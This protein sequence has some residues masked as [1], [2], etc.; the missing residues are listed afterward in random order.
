MAA[1]LAAS[2][3][4]TRAEDPGPV[5]LDG[6]PSSEQAVAATKPG[7]VARAR[8]LRAKLNSLGLYPTIRA[9]AEGTGIGPGLT[10]WKPRAFGGPV[11]FLATVGWSPRVLLA[12]ARLGRVP[13]RPDHIPDRRFTLEALTTDPLGDP[14]HQAFL[15]L[16]ARTIK[17]K[18]DRL[19]FS[20]APNGPAEPVPLP[21]PARTPDEAPDPVEIV[22]DVRESDADLVAGYHFFQGLSASARVGYVRART[23]FD[24]DQ[25]LGAAE[26]PPVPG[27]NDTTDFARVALDLVVDRR[28]VRSRAR[29]GGLLHARWL[30]MDQRGGAFYG[31]E[32]LELDRR[33]FVADPSRRHVLAG[34][35]FGAWDEPEPG[36][37]VPF[38]FQRALGGNHTLRSYPFFRFRGTRLLAF[39]AEYRLSLLRWLE[40]AA[41]YDGGHVS[42]GVE[43]LGSLGYRDSLG[44]S[45]R[46]VS[47]DD[48]ILR[49][50]A[51]HGDEGWRLAATGAFPF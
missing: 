33:A 44:A 10:F 6:P 18:R 40:L 39:S 47:E 22:F 43:A 8:A 14:N 17:V 29:R 19:F 35:F 15:F 45:L 5:R 32:R 11:G 50:F 28:D 30:R 21:R 36:K 9:M 24:P 37:V 51:A 48:V 12:E 34:R 13:S 38:Y 27:V 2:A 31:F 25:V 4:A 1:G 3:G 16:E 20:E 42:G 23:H 46:W 49:A 41:F 26:L 7:I